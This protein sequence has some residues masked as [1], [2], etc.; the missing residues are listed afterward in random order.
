MEWLKRE[1]EN[2]ALWLTWE[3]DIGPELPRC[4]SIES[5]FLPERGD[6]TEEV[7]E[8]DKPI[9][10]MGDAERMNKAIENHA[11]LHRMEKI[12]LAMR[13][14]G[15]PVVFRFHR[16]GEHAAKKLADNAEVKLAWYF[17]GR[18]ELPNGPA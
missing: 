5:R 15:L 14:G 18:R 6:T 8:P 12:A 4:K 2:W 10:R 7:R 11:G 13:Y 16:M 3:A 9:P 17:E 1:L